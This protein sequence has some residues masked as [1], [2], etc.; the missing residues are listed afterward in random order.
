ME[1]RTGGRAPWCRGLHPERASPGGWACLA[2]RAPN[3]SGCRRTQDSLSLG[4]PPDPR[5]LALGR[6][7]PQ[8]PTRCPPAKQSGPQCRR[9]RPAVRSSQ[10]RAH[11]PLQ[12]WTLLA[13]LSVRSRPRTLLP[14]HPRGPPGWAAD[15]RSTRDRVRP[16]GLGASLSPLH[17]LEGLGAA[18]IGPRG[19]RSWNQ[20]NAKRAHRWDGVHGCPCSLRRPPN[21]AQR[22]APNLTGLG[23][24]LKVIFGKRGC[25]PFTLRDQSPSHPP[26]RWVGVFGSPPQPVPS[27]QS[28]VKLGGQGASQHRRQRN[29]CKQRTSHGRFPNPATTERDGVLPPSERCGSGDSGVYPVSPSGF[30]PT[31]GLTPAPA[32]LAAAPGCP[33]L[34]PDESWKTGRAAGSTGSAVAGHAPRSRRAEEGRAGRDQRA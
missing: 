33:L 24:R 27:S 10:R 30:P 34:G 19:T 28:W 12:L 9:P 1:K 15:L 29:P 4:A 2:G 17:K 7:P 21:P 14:S 32:A 3:Q 18:W 6:S 11:R 25:S 31:P 23:S 13:S 8:G 22:S 5:V 16:A 20:D 26:G